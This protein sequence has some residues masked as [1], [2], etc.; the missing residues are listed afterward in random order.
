MGVGVGVGVFLCPPEELELPPQA[1][2][3]NNRPVRNSED[4]AASLRAIVSYTLRPRSVS[5]VARGGK[6]ITIAGA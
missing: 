1:L 5:E 3:S 2:R 4:Q 6:I